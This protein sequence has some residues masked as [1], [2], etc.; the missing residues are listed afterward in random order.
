MKI[1]IVSD[2]HLNKMMYKKILD[3][4]FQQ[5]PFRSADFMR[6]FAWSVLEI[7]KEHPSLVII[8]GDVYDL[9]DVNNEVRGFFSSQCEKLINNKIPIILITG[10]HDVCKRHHAL[11][12]I[13][14]LKLKNLIVYDKPDIFD[15][16]GYSL[17]FFP[18][19]L[20]IERKNV[21]IKEEFDKFLKKVNE[22]PKDKPKIFFGHFGVRGAKL[23]EYTEDEELAR[24][25]VKLDQIKTK[26]YTN[27]NTDDLSPDDLDK[28]DVKYVFMGDF[29]SFQFIDTKNC[30]AMYTGSLERNNFN[31]ISNK[32][33]FVIYDDSLPEE[34]KMGRT[35][36]IEYLH[37]RPM[38]EIFG[39]FSEIKEKFSTL[40]HGK[41]KGAIIK[42]SCIGNRQD[43]ISF[44][45]GLDAF[46]KEIVEKTDAVYIL[47]KR[48][49][50]D[51]PDTKALSIIEK[52]ME[53]Q[54]HLEE[55]DILDVVK[56]II[57]ESTKDEKEIKAMLDL[58]SDIYKKAINNEKDK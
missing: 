34:G 6:A 58:V 53:E 20:D 2:L 50:K 26:A 52:E 40:D 16:K 9:Y 28:L 33:G 11:Q 27:Y 10:N 17:L 39:N 45:A 7:I 22:L 54:G 3:K 12:D 43:F 36:F 5:L 32:K 15:F 37:C 19:S 29:H 1:A 4:E 49:T 48:I 30:R 44:L 42:L 13:K 57:S 25:Y 35:K 47:H 41:Y 21:T 14:D 24:S 55:S 31:E 46:K 38:I 23:N 56:D 8:C 51:S 18:Y